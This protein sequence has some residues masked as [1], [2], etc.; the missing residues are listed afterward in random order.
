M[1][2]RDERRWKKADGDG[3]GKL[4]K[5]EFAHFLHP[6][7]AKHMQDIVV[8]VSVLSQPSLSLQGPNPQKSHP[9]HGGHPN[10][11]VGNFN[12]KYMYMIEVFQPDSHDLV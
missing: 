11:F 12:F 6:E 8:E 7:E 5:E 1:I 9:G 3:D 4:T 10:L 2:K